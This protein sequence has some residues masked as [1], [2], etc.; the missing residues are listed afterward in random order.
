[1][2]HR[3]QRARTLIFALVAALVVAACGAGPRSLSDLKAVPET[4]LHP[5]DARFVSH[6]ESE[7]EQTIDGPIAAIVGDVFATDSDADAILAFYE[8]ELTRRGYVRDVRDGWGV[9]TT[10]EVTV[11]LWRHDDVI[12][13][14]AIYR[15]DDPRLPALPAELPN[16]TLFELALA[17]AHPTSPGRS[18]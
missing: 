6:N 4:G 13:R 5:P 18:G 7:A 17:N 9:R 2:G 3:T 16:G 14:V 11:W 15:A 12:A 10:I 8:T 1:L